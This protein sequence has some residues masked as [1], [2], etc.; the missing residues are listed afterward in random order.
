MSE[1]KYEILDKEK[2]IAIIDTQLQELEIQHF[3]LAMSE[4]NRLQTDTDN[5]V[6]WQQAISQYE[7]AINKLRNQKS[8]IENG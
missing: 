1:F 3:S 7:A 6:K 2:K 4:P 5:Y 8:K